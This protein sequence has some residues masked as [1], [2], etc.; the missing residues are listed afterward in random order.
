MSNQP[1]IAPLRPISRY[2]QIHRGY[3]AYPYDLTDDMSDNLGSAGEHSYSVRLHQAI[4]SLNQQSKLEFLYLTV[5]SL[6]IPVRVV[7]L[8]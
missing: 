7:A 2:I 8:V 3:T 1:Y 5:L 6:V 4:L